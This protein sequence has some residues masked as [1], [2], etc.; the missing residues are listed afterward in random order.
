MMKI[1][2]HL[3]IRTIT[4][5][6]WYILGFTLALII[7]AISSY[8]FWQT[9]SKEF[10]TPETL[11]YEQLV[12]VVNE[13]HNQANE[14]QSTEN[15]SS[16]QITQYQQRVDS[17]IAPLQAPPEELIIAQYITNDL[18]EAYCEYLQDFNN[19]AGSSAAVYSE[20]ERQFEL[21]QQNAKIITALSA[22]RGIPTICTY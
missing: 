11:Y 15:V 4:E 1:H 9:I 19:G 2:H 16:D 20:I 3:I 22:Y 12:N 7:I 5:K 17:L 18:Y 10:L 21:F 14:L 6:R 8:Y 13:M